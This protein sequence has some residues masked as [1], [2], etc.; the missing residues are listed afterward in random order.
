MLFS[1]LDGSLLGLRFQNNHIFKGVGGEGGEDMATFQ[2]P[3]LFQHHSQYV[4]F[5]LS[6]TEI[7]EGETVGGARNTL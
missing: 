7:S 5:G 4:S 2:K 1:T 6:I 3:A